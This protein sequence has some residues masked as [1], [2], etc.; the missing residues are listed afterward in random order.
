MSA[1]IGVQCKKKSTGNSLWAI[2]ETLA[3]E[4]G[5]CGQTADLCYSR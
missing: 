2:H 4:G 5:E 1:Y 3:S